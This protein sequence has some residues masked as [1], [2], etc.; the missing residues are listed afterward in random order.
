M[1]VC[2]RRMVLQTSMLTSPKRRFC[3]LTITTT[4]TTTTA[5][6]T[7]PA[8]LLLQEILLLLLLL[9]LLYTGYSCNYSDRCIIDH[10]HTHQLQLSGEVYAL[11]VRLSCTYATHRARNNKTFR[12]KIDH[13]VDTNLRYLNVINC[14]KLNSLKKYLLQETY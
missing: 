1:C 3:R 9:L 12:E 2:P 14:S 13:E 8:T 7:T 5:V 11:R 10:V 6:S 4:I